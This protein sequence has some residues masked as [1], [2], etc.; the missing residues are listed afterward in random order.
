M[1]VMYFLL[2]AEQF[3]IGVLERSL[4]LGD[5]PVTKWRDNLCAPDTLSLTLASILDKQTLST[6]GVIGRVCVSLQNALLQHSMIGISAA[7]QELEELLPEIVQGYESGQYVAMLDL[8]ESVAASNGSLLA[9]DGHALGQCMCT[10]PAHVISLKQVANWSSPSTFTLHSSSAYKAESA[11]GNIALVDVAK[12]LSAML[13]RYYR[14]RRQRLVRCPTCG[15][16]CMFALSLSPGR[17]LCVHVSEEGNKDSRKKVV[18][19]LAHLTYA[20]LSFALKALII[21]SGAHYVS[22]FHAHGLGW[23]S[24]DGWYFYDGLADIKLLHVG[25]KLQV[26]IAH[27]RQIEMLL[28]VETT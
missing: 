16:A 22:Y 26:E 8:W 12:T 3:T 6:A 28:Y 20:S 10:V 14:A 9:L 24:R 2:S 7:Q 1:Y 19:L 15:H 23:L 4:H 13:G 11:C 21:H 18:P 25:A 5:A 17:V 27:S